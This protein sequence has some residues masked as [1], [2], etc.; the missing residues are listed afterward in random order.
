MT[1]TEV[2]L[3]V[4]AEPVYQPLLS[5]GWRYNEPR[6]RSSRTFWTREQ[7]ENAPITRRHYQRLEVATLAGVDF[8]ELRR[9]EQATDL[10]CEGAGRDE[11]GDW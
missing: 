4:G 5:L 3:F 7:E 8:A 1:T 10:A 9:W 11:Q 2:Q 6:S